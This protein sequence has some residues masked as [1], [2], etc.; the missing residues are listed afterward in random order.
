MSVDKVQ[1]T[2]LKKDNLNFHAKIEISLDDVNTKL[3][4]EAAKHAKSAKINGFRPGKVPVSYIKKTYGESIKQDIINNLVSSN[5]DK[6]IKDNNLNLVTDPKI[7]EFKLEN[8][9]ASFVIKCELIPDIT[10]PPLGNIEIEKPVVTI[11]QE[12]IDTKLKALAENSKTYLKSSKSKAEMGDQVTLDAIGYIENVAFDGGNLKNHK[13]VLGS[14]TFIDNF[15]QQLV[16][17][18][19]D[20]EVDVNVN[21]PAHY[22]AKDLAGKPALFKVKV[23]EVHK[24][25][26]PKV[27]EE[28][29]KKFNFDS[30]DK[31]QSQASK[32]IE[33]EFAGSIYTIMKM[34]LFDK[35]EKMLD[36]EVPDSLVDKEYNTLK[37]QAEQIDESDD[38]LKSMSEEEK[39]A[40]YKRIAMRRVRIGL[41]LS[42][43]AKEK[44]IRIEQEDIWQA[45]QQQARMFPGNEKQIYEYFQKNP[46]AVESLKSP[47]LEEKA[48]QQ[49]FDSEVKLIE[50]EYS[51]HDLEKLISLE[52]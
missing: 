36:F 25:S 47:I 6:F 1:I 11:N 9:N 8:D 45:V 35:L 14:K 3:E 29:A 30:L 33:A 13:L 40:Y 21:F 41:M 4:V 38:S 23:I 51:T 28:F 7:E 19:T 2:E 31:L 24:P 5:V 18:K 52:N 37:S 16:G 48:V 42:E 34:Q 26:V 15:E 12:D 44:N 43:Y 10:L 46:K 17:T 50:K 27:D 49:I 20:D 39:E 22:H 32:N